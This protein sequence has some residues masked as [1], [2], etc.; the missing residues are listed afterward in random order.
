MACVARVHIHRH[1]KYLSIKRSVTAFRGTRAVIIA[2]YGVYMSA[3]PIDRALKRVIIA[4]HF[5]CAVPLHPFRLVV[6]CAEYGAIPW[7][8]H[9]IHRPPPTTSTILRVPRVQ[10]SSTLSAS[11]GQGSLSLEGTA[12]WIWGD[13]FFGLIVEET[14]IF[15]RCWRLLVEGNVVGCEKYVLILWWILLM[16][17]GYKIDRVNLMNW[18]DETVYFE[19]KSWFL[20]VDY[21]WNV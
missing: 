14:L 4:L 21:R 12:G 1:A 11:S 9:S 20:I 8:R 7:T 6:S 17:W 13:G 2:G 3:N 19:V 10:S 18:L 16:A 15:K 5:P